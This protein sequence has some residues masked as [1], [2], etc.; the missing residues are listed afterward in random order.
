M[1][2]LSK[3]VIVFSVMFGGLVVL[4]P[5]TALAAKCEL[6]VGED[7][8]WYTEGT[9][10][11]KGTKVTSDADEKLKA[12]KGAS[13]DLVGKILRFVNVLSALVI[14]FAVGMIVYAGFKYITSQGDP[15]AVESAKQQLWYSGVGLFIVLTAFTILQ[16]F[17]NASG[18]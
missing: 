17:K 2:I 11:A 13:E 7:G 8:E 3:L 1:Q 5:A 14:V 18:A 16:L 10:G 15:K 9:N 4:T 6:V 12:C